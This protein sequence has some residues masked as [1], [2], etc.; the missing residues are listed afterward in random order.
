MWVFQAQTTDEAVTRIAEGGLPLAGGTVLVPK[1]VRGEYERTT[2]VDIRRLTSLKEIK[3]S[4]TAVDI[5]SGVTLIQLIVN[6]KSPGL[7]QALT[8][9]A[10]AVGN[11]HVRNIATVAGNLTSGLAGADLPTAFL[12]LDAEVTHQG[13]DGPQTQP[14]AQIMESGLPPG[15][16]ITSILIPRNGPRVSAFSKFAWRRASGKT[17]VNVA[18][19]LRITDGRVAAATVAVG[20]AGPHAVRLRQAESIIAGRALDRNL[21]EEAAKAAASEVIFT[22]PHS[23]REEYRR[24]LVAA[25]VRE[26]LTKLGAF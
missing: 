1:I 23:S 8:E 17:I 11:P 9:A 21:T 25:G 12:A 4:E 14:L 13:A 22:R 7:D 16:L 26:I 19:S 3:V 18:V 20:G 6:R 15:R 24:R 10:A 2:F 5:G